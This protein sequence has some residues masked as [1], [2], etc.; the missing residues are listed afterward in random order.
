MVGTCGPE[1]S[2]EVS[3]VMERD[4]Q[5]IQIDQ[6]VEENCEQEDWVFSVTQNR[7]VGWRAEPDLSQIEEELASRAGDLGVYLAGTTV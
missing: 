6:E 2:D 7:W 5:F 4:A 1:G 3:T